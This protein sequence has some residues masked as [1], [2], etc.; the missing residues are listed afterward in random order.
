MNTFTNTFFTTYPYDLYETA[1]N[2]GNLAYTGV[3]LGL[4]KA[5]KS[6]WVSIGFGITAV[7]LRGVFPLP[8]IMG[9]SS[10]TLMLYS[11]SLYR[12]YSRYLVKLSE[13]EEKC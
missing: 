2:T 12:E 9:V 5:Q 6:F 13:Y 10:V 8:Y 4:I 11:L 1:S 7:V 3:A